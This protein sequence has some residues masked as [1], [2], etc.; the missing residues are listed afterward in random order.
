MK[1]LKKKY[2]DQMKEVLDNQSLLSTK[3]AIGYLK[4]GIKELLKIEVK[5]KDSNGKEVKR[6]LNINEFI[7]NLVVYLD[8]VESAIT[9]ELKKNV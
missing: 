2:I 5:D 7:H 4:N 3:M 6:H 8:Q 9:E 1:P